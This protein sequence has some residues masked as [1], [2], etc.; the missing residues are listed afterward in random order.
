VVDLRVFADTNTLYPFYVCDLLLHCAEEDLFEILWSEDLFAELIK[1]IPRSGRKSLPVVERMCAAIREA[2]P[3]GEIPRKAYEYLIDQ[4][5]GP[6][7]DD[8]IHS[9]AA[10]GGHADVL[11][12]RDT[13][14][15]P[16][17]AL[18]K[19]GLRVT[20]VD[21]FLC[22]QFALFPDDLIRV[23]DNQAADLTRSRLT[24]DDLLNQLGHQSGAPRFAQRVHR[25][26]RSTS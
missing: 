1:V 17:T 19:R 7:P 21:Q 25:Y 8:H 4:M 9:A 10:I 20:T 15:F 6:D 11:L 3:D 26:L 18:R 12:T 14:G 2:F 24:R 5:P 22:E 13:K 23:L 16:P